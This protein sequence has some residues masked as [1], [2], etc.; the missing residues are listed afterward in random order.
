MH[1]VLM[2]HAWHILKKNCVFISVGNTSVNLGT[3]STVFKDLS[4]K[5]HNPQVHVID[6]SC[7]ILQI[8]YPVVAAAL[9]RITAA[10]DLM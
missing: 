7:H 5:I 3:R 1:S 4:K 10:A 6:C 2:Q 8:I 9:A